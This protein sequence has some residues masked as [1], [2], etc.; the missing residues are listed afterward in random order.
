MLAI[1]LLWVYRGSRRFA[2][3]RGCR[4]VVLSSRGK[5]SSSVL[6]GLVAAA[7]DR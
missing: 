7:C 2:R 4:A 5:G 3:T 6:Q 1:P